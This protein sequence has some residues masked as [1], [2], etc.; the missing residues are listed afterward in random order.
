MMPQIAGTHRG[1][2]RM[3]NWDDLRSELR[4]DAPCG[5]MIDGHRR[6]CGG[7]RI[8]ARSPIDGRVLAEFPGATA[9]DVAAAVRAA[10]DAFVAWR[11]VPAPV[12]GASRNWPNS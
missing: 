5:L 4:V 6:G 2:G 8:V 10:H 7:E 1:D 11:V 9:D 3:T 12:R